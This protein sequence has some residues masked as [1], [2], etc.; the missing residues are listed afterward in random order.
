MSGGIWEEY[1]QGDQRKFLLPCPHCEEMIELTW[2]QKDKEGK[3]RYSLAFDE[4]AKMEDGSY[5]FLKVA[6][7]TYY[8]CQKCDG[9]ILDAH[10]PEMLKGGSWEAMNPQAPVGHRSYHLNS[11]YAPAVSFLL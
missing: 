1:L 11:L 4:D 7:T 10:K 5:D 6:S 2:R 8:R 9:K 3:T